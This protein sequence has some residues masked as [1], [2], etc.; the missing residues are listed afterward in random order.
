MT[1]S[2]S[3]PQGYEEEAIGT[4]LGTKRGCYCS[5]DNNLY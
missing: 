4:W 5:D 1:K 2:I 3:C